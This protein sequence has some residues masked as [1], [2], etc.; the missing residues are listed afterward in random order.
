MG[1]QFSVADAYLFVMLNWARFMQVDVSALPKLTAL[2]G[3]IAARPK[4]QATL[5]AEGLA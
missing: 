5:K 3:R 1:N 2:F 4:V